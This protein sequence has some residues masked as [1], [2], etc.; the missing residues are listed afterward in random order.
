MFAAFLLAFAIVA[1]PLGQLPAS[2]PA[3]DAERQLQALVEQYYAAYA[4]EDLRAMEALWHPDGPAKDARKV[5]EAEFEA[6]DATLERARLFDVAVDAGGGRARGLIELRVTV[7][8]H[9][10]LERRA[11][12]LTFLPYAGTWRLWNEAS[13]GRRLAARAL[14]V[15]PDGLDA[16][17]AAEPELL[18]DDA[19]DGLATEAMTARTRGQGSEAMRATEVR[20]RLARTAG[21][22]GAVASSLTEIG[23]QHQMVGR[24][25]EA[26]Q[27]FGEARALVARTG[28][29][30]ELAAAEM[31]VAAIDYLEARYAAAIEGYERARR[32]FEAEGD[33]ARTAGV[34]HSLGNAHYMLGEYERALDAYTLAG[35]LHEKAG[36]RAAL[37][38]VHLASGLVHRELGNY[39]EA[40]A[41][42]RTAATLADQAGDTVSAARAWQGLGEVHRLEGDFAAALAALRS[43]LERW[44]KT[45]DVPGRTAAL[46]A[47][48]Q[49]Q[50][51]LRNFA[52]AVEWYEQAIEVDR[53]IQ[54]APGIA[55][56]LGGLGGAHLAQGRADL[57]Q[58]E[59]EESLALREQ[60]RD[61]RGVTWTLV[62]LA[63]LH[64]RASR[65][66]DAIRVGR[67]AVG[68]AERLGDR[69]ALCTAWAV[70]AAAQV[71]GG[72]PDAGLASAA[73]AADLAGSIGQFD[74][75]AY[76]RTAS[77]R[78]HVRLGRPAEGQAAFEE[79]VA[80]LTRVP[81]GPGADVFF[82]D[83]RAPYLALVDLYAGLNR[84]ADALAWLE[85]GR[86]HALAVMLG[87]DGVIV[88]KGLTEA[89]REEERRLLKASRSAAVKLRREELR[90]R[91]DADRQAQLREELASLAS[92]RASLRERLF[93]AH[94][95]LRGLRARDDPA[96]ISPAAL[97]PRQAALTYSIGDAA[98]RVFV[99]SPSSGPGEAEA[100]PRVN[101]ATVDIPAADLAALV[102]RFREAILARD[103]KVDALAVELHK[104]L[105]AP[106]AEWL[107]PATDLLVAPDAFLWGL[108]FEA[109][110]AAS[111]RYLIEDVSVSYVPS[112]AS[113]ALYREGV[114]ASAP[115]TATVAAPLANPPV[116]E[117][118]AMARPRPRD[119]KPAD[120]TAEA[121]AVAAVFGAGARLLAGA[122]ATA[123]RL[124]TTAPG[125]GVLHLAAPVFLD[126]ASPFYSAIVLSPTGPEPGSGLVEAGDLLGWDLAA[127]LA[128]VSR[129]EP[130]Q[131]H[132]SGDAL[133]ALS[134]SFLVAGT[135]ALA[136]SRWPSSPL[137]G[138]ADPLT[139]AFYREWLRPAA[140][141]MERPSAAAALRRA[142]RRLLAAPATRH[143]WSWARMMAI[144]SP[145]LPPRSD[146][147]AR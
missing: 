129:A 46:F 127:D 53:A 106:A 7:R 87:E 68:E 137:P 37:A 59:Y 36:S 39:N 117:R 64:E 107:A 26:A 101:V 30:R 63:A 34:L 52:R 56:D 99:V 120:A 2:M 29:P 35:R 123:E 77:G 66:A 89:E 50:A 6:R 122:Q 40:T 73:R 91:P 33:E 13:A 97:G 86:H 136:V 140:A 121:R 80:A 116:E 65:P 132:P 49:V 111:G 102:A 96:T 14:T 92:T 21:H 131:A 94:P 103:A 124:A 38:V 142:A 67:R 45:P 15:E 42:Y 119:A 113:A 25:A 81:V 76:A 110:R 3:G 112:L 114:R 141:G 109:L 41:A 1:R 24:Y 88:S 61:G 8:G 128:V 125:G 83:R 72:D 71:A 47:T 28:T 19:I 115:R 51:H 105:I 12:D 82:D 5:L 93:A 90:D 98:L 55:R 108:P 20:L 4:R 95:A 75:L 22:D 57:A 23:L 31:N 146:R 135:P 11:R 32:T 70:M 100:P 62:H 144:T 139:R 69:S 60:L 130:L 18:S 74:V 43:S 85:R 143:P 138:R 147:S 10:R 78:A 104:R 118:I 48:G 134:W 44:E 58:A 54:D 79:A 16:A 27:A 145:P 17:T 126:D 133:T 84:P 9:T